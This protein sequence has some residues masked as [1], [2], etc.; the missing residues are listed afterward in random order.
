MI[1]WVSSTLSRTVYKGTCVDSVELNQK[2][3]GLMAAWT[4]DHVESNAANNIS[5]CAWGRKSSVAPNS[6]PGLLKQ[7][8]LPELFSCEAR[9]NLQVAA[10]SYC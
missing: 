1:L 5:R 7:Q 6:K 8:H 10:P 9:S 4:V 2:L 3:S